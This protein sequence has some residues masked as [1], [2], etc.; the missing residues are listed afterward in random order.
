MRTILKILNREMRT[1]LKILNR[2]AGTALTFGAG[3]ETAHHAKGSVSA[4][5][6][7]AVIEALD[8]RQ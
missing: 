5:A 6:D 2:K 7:A 4:Q 3:A 8:H 1:I